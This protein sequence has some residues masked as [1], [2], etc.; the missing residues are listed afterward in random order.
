MHRV[1]RRWLSLVAGVCGICACA[2]G[3]I[4][5]SHRATV[6]KP[7]FILLPDASG[8]MIVTDTATPAFSTPL[9]TY[10]DSVIVEFTVDGYVMVR[11]G[12]YAEPDKF[13]GP[14]DG[15]GY[16]RQ[17]ECRVQVR[18]TY[19]VGGWGPGVCGG[20]FK[21]LW[22]DTALVKGTG[23]LT[24]GGPIYQQPYECP[25]DNIPPRG[26][27]CW[28]YSG[29]E[30]WAIKPLL[31]PINLTTPGT[32]EAAPGVIEKP[33]P[34]T[35]TL[36]KIAAKPDSLK[37]IRV[38]IRVISW[39]WEAAGGGAGQTILTGGATAIQRS[40]YIQ[41]E[42]RMIVDAFVNGVE[43][44]D[45]TSV[46]VPVV[47]IVPQSDSMRPSIRT[48]SRAEL[49]SQTVAVSVSGFNGVPLLNKPVALTALATEGT[50]GHSHTGS[51]PA[52]DFLP[53]G[54]STRQVNTGAS[55][56][57]TATYLAPDPSGPVT[58][59]G[60]SPGATTTNKT[61]V[62]RI[63]G[64]V[65][66]LPAAHYDTTGGTQTHPY[67]VNHYADPSHLAKLGVIAD[68]FY[69]KFG[70]RIK[71]N[72]SSLPLGGLFDVGAGAWLT[73]HKGHREGRNTDVKTQGLSNGMITFIDTQWRNCCGQPIDETNTSQP[74]YH[75]VSK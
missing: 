64:L 15:Q 20:A 4:S 65:Q 61:I 43:Q 49:S 1:V 8:H 46:V 63:P 34:G 12:K 30:T 45:T 22:I 57:Y 75:L 69:A 13:R 6:P 41:E 68:R 5:P 71:F 72:D 26:T 23:T 33:Q 25:D 54:G 19:T 27:L 52:G 21:G 73:P 36:F 70:L 3:P 38:P 48:P 31:A 50:A 35:W 37:R 14:L 59:R 11:E 17:N 62:V 53:E 24:R 39:R 58:I 32:I 60:T 9:P 18:F 47:K 28:K 29:D 16:S 74:H 66:Y 2:D 55:G 51:K 67:T 10:A 56:I 42:G 44:I 40:V 7:A